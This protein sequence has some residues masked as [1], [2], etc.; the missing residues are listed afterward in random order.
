M[1]ENDDD[2][3]DDELSFFL[4]SFLLSLALFFA[5]VDGANA[6]GRTD[7]QTS[8]AKPSN[9]VISCSS[10]PCSCPSSL[11]LD[12]D[13]TSNRF[14]VRI[15]FIGDDS[16]DENDEENFSVSVSFSSQQLSS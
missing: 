2:D 10:S 14:P 6:V 3:D 8:V 1:E 5:T 13:T 11:F 15:N 16:D 7:V 4:L 9:S 12:T